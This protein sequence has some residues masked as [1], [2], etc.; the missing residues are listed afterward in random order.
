MTHVS[1]TIYNE[2][3]SKSSLYPSRVVPIPDEIKICDVPQDEQIKLDENTIFRFSSEVRNNCLFL[4]LTEI[5]AFCPHFYEQMLTL[6]KIRE[7]HKMFRACDNLQEV[8]EYLDILFKKKKFKLTKENDKK[9]TLEIT[10]K[11]L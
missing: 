4:K 11:L 6:D 5:G 2:E 1:S 7:I 10:S 3:D 8:K 9:I